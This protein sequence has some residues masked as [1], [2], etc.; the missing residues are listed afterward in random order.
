MATARDI[1]K[2]ALR[3]ISAIGTGAPLP[4]EEASQGLEV[5]NDMLST[6]S[7]EGDLVFTETRETFNLT[8]AASYTIGS[9][10]DF[11]TTRPLYFNAV[12]VSQGSI[13]YPLTMIDN[14]QYANIP[15]KTTGSI[16]DVY[17]YDTGYPLGT[18]FLFPAPSAASTI[19]L[20]SVKPLTSFTSLD[21]DFAMPEEYKSA[22]IYNLATW[23]APEYER[24]ASPTVQRLAKRTKSAVVAQNKRNENYMAMLD[25]SADRKR[26]SGNIYEGYFT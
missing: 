12:Y 20:Y 3:K 1:I 5:L 22:L 4:A 7:A 21:T 10:G 15:L 26:D 11:D 17:Y 18:I 19:T 23:I 13:D 24:E 25:V 16:P 6:W 9:G 8:S 2:S 14:K